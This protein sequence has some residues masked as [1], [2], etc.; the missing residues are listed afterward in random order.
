MAVVSVA[1]FQ[2]YIEQQ[3]RVK[4]AMQERID[5]LHQSIVE[6]RGQIAIVETSS[7]TRLTQVVDG[8][9]RRMTDIEVRG[10]QLI[11]DTQC[12]KAELN[13][14]E[15][16]IKEL[17]GNADVNFK[18]LHDSTKTSFDDLRNRTEETSV[19]VREGF[20]ELQSFQEVQ[21]T[22]AEI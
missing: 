19:K 6:I 14:V 3:V 11:S 10:N 20:D 22:I 15:A 21:R 16:Q 7:E 12:S 8:C 2:Q 18:A 13:T 17:M 9:D 5:E 1:G 4:E